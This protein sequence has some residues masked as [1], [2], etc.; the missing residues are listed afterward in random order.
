M[1]PCRVALNE[2]RM[3]FMAFL[4]PDKTFKVNGVTVKEY[5]LTKHNPNKIAMPATSMD[6]EGVTIHNTDTI[7]TATGTTQAE[8]YTRATVNG[9]MNDVR[10][11]YYCDHVEAWQD[12]PLTLS[13]WHAADGSGFGNRK[14]VAIECIMSSAYNAN[15]KKA[16]DNAARLAAWL[17]HQKGLGIDRLYTHSH[18]MN[19]RDGKTGTVDYLNTAH[20]AYKN[21]PAYILP[22]WSAFKLK[23]YSYLYELNKASTST[24]TPSTPKPTGQIYRIRKSWTDAK[25]QI[26]AYRNLNSAKAL[27]DKNP[28]YSVYNEAGKAV[29]SN[30]VKAKT[31]TTGAKVK[32]NNAAFYAASSSKSAARTGVSG[33][34]YIWSATVI[35]NRVRITTQANLVGKSGQVTAWVPVSNI[36]VL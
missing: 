16:E 36:T 30:I 1:R 18:H 32:L 12:L 22:H 10:V 19:V 28:G 17:L 9:N 8:Q 13:G 2:E 23:V 25:S 14:T 7:N 24:T 33:T 21:C 31:I 11:H 5:L 3:I 26:G 20:N 29:Y 6:Y 34:Y 27:C 15:D 4:T 35:N